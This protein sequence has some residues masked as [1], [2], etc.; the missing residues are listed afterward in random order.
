MLRLMHTL[1]YL[2]INEIVIWF[3]LVNGNFWGC[4]LS[5][6]WDFYQALD[7]KLDES[8]RVSPLMY[9]YTENV[10]ERVTNGLVF[11]VCNFH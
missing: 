5:S 6:F 9:M 7:E 2:D 11:F 10:L 8:I 4:I 3:H 1:S